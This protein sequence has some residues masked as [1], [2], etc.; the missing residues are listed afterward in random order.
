MA[1]MSIKDRSFW[2]NG[3]SWLKH[4]KEG[5]GSGDI[6]FFVL[7]EEKDNPP[8]ITALKM[9]P[10]YVLPRHAHHC[11]RFE[12]IVQGTLDVGDKI[13]TVGDVM[14]SAPHEPYGPHVA[15]PEG[16]TTFEIFGDF[17]SATR[18]ILTGAEGPIPCDTSTPEGYKNVREVQRRLREMAEAAGGLAARRVPKINPEK[19]R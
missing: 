16:C 10:G 5:R 17:K 3:P 11:W 4:M 19:D 6:A 8:S 1:F 7:G 18:P 2:E 15:G 9:Q 14:M 13:L 12:V